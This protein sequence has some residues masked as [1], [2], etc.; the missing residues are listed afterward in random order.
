MKKNTLF[1]IITVYLIFSLLL[2]SCT[3]N[4]GIYNP[5]NFADEDL[6]TLHIDKTISV[7][8]VNN[9]DVKW[10]N[11]HTWKG[12]YPQIVRIPAGRYTF[13]VKYSYGNMYS[14]STIPVS[15]QLE[16]GN[17]YLL[18]SRVHR[19]RSFFNSSMPRVTYHVLKYNNRKKG[20]EVTI[21]PLDNIRRLNPN[22]ITGKTLISF[23]QGVLHRLTVNQNGTF[24]YSKNENIYHGTWTFDANAFMYRYI[25]EWTENGE[26]Q[27]YIMD[28]TSYEGVIS[29]SGRWTV[30][31]AQKPFSL[32]LLF[33][34]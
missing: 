33:V 30:T 21:N 1:V 10:K 34:D 4:R 28:F 25:F 19:D 16:R 26:K 8:R 18:T 23:D 31:D 15:A 5:G 17:T 24:E 29:W 27:G 22:D 20:D 11:F 13:L 14:N 7:E 12:H 9:E 32:R 6:V 3:S 2:T